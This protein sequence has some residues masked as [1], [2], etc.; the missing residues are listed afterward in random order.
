M[1][2]RKLEE[3]DATFMFEWMHDNVVVGKLQT[4]F[5]EKTLKDC[6][7]FIKKAQDLSS[8]CHMAIADDNNEYMGTVSL[9]N[10]SDGSAEFA[11]TVRKCAMGKGFSSFAMK[12]IIRLG[13]EKYKLQ[14]IY[15]CVNPENIRAVRFYD[16]NG[17]A[18]I[19]GNKLNIYGYTKKQIEE[20]LWYC[21]ENSVLG[22]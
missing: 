17:Y 1:N 6:N 21:V 11:I 22:R 5:S 16:K 4:N 14:T 13:F 12:E 20:Y 19:E 3:K 18:R 10:I 15:W 9:K 8:N 7:E 2:L